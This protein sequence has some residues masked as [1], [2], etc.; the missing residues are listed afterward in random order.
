[1][2]SF[3]ASIEHKGPI[4]SKSNDLFFDKNLQHVYEYHGLF[5][6]VCDDFGIDKTAFLEIFGTDEEFSAWESEKT[7]KVDGL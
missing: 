6:S 4:S 5:K 3:L 7:G 2:G 1:M